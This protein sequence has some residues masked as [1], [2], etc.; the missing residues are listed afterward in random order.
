MK[1]LDCTL[2]DG[3]YINNWRFNNTFID[4][5]I[6]ITNKYRN[7]IEYIEIGFINIKKKYRDEIV[8]NLR[9]LS[10]EII[11]KFSSKS[12]C[13]IAV[14]A[15]LKNINLDLLKNNLLPKKIDLI[16]IAF[17]KKEIEKTI[18]VTKR[19]IELGYKVS[20]NIMAITN[21]T[22]E[23]VL[24]LI[25]EINKYKID[26]VYLADSYGSLN[27]IELKKLLDIFNSNTTKTGL[28]LHN[29]MQNAI[30]NF[31]YIQKYTNK[32]YLIDTTMFGMG[33][34]AG[35]LPLETT[36]ISLDN[37]LNLETFISLLNFINKEIKKS[38]YKNINSWGYD[39]DYLLS[40]YLSIHPNYVSKMRDMEIDMSNTFKLLQKIKSQNEHKYFNKDFLLN[41]VDKN[42]E[43][44]I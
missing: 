9:N 24:N 2:R 12:K 26:Y 1:I 19:L 11:N 34:G 13:K 36:L 33:R 8:G 28:H 5:Y 42:N 20:L 17:H 16:R 37:K 40:G 35:N 29:N 3:G 38:F 25:K 21:Y 30:S 39:L 32:I 14:M 4:N 41:L 15:D 23:E 22:E 27:N 44:L 31:N 6:D 10:I 18:N 7:Y 43:E